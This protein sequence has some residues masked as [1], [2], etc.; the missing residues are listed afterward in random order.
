M[1]PCP[2]CSKK[3]LSE[4]IGLDGSI[5]ACQ[6]CK[7]KFTQFKRVYEELLKTG[8]SEK[9]ADRRMSEMLEQTI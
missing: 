6:A 7:D 1:S 3:P 8:L 5:R 9:E 4:L 2:V